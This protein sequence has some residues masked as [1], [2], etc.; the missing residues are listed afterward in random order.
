MAKIALLVSAVVGGVLLAGCGAGGGGDDSTSVVSESAPPPAP[1]S[2]PTT[3]RASNFGLTKARARKIKSLAL[4]DRFVRQV[5]SD[6]QV[7]VAKKVV[8]WVS[9][10][11]GKL[12]GGSVDVYLSPPARL[13]H[14]RLPATISPNQKAPAGT[15]T[16]YR[17]VWMS[18]RDVRQ[19]EV[20]VE[21]E[22]GRA[23]RIEP[24]GDGYEVTDVELIGSPPESPAYAPEPGY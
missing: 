11:G 17:Y 9:E 3:S 4:R 19:L 1:S 14:Q 22:K 13:D 8:P 23:V 20:A 24:A 10:G 2:R 7:R 18:A 5:A 21:L 15:A 12:I 16:L 6:S